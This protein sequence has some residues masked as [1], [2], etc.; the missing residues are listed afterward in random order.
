MS[1]KIQKL[2]KKRRREERQNQAAERQNQRAK[3]SPQ[4]QLIVLDNRLG[5]NIGAQKERQKLQDLIN[6][7]KFGKRNK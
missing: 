4:Q 5:K 2:Y 6:N 3:R 1:E 7:A